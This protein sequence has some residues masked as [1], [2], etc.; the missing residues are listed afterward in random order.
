[1]GID[2]LGVDILGIDILAPTR[3]KVSVSLIKK[4]FLFMQETCIQVRAFESNIALTR[5]VLQISLHDDP[6]RTCLI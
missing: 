4:P 6:N 3:S 1:M 5:G 2:I